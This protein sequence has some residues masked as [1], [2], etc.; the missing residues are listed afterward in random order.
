MVQLGECGRIANRI[1]RD[2]WESLPRKTRGGIAGGLVLLENLHTDFTLEIAA[3]K[4][5]GSD[6]LKNATAANVQ[7]ILAEFGESRLLVKEGGRTN[8]GLVKSLT[9]LLRNMRKAGLHNL[10][11]KERNAVL[12]EMQAF[13]AEKAKDELNAKKITFAYRKGMTSREV[14][15]GILAEAAKRKKAGEIAEYLI[16]AKLALRFPNQSIRNT[17]AS[18]ADEQ[19][20]EPGD[21]KIHD[22]VFHAT[23]SP[24]RGHYDKCRVNLD[25]GLRVFLLVPDAKLAGTRQSVE[26]DLENRVSVESIESFVSQNIEE[27]SEFSG[28]KIMG[29]FVDLLEKYNSRVAEVEANLSLQIEIPASLKKEKS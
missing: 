7:K 21:F 1:I 17:S 16:G 24:N 9:P 15:G 11:L 27:L 19:T 4:A 10:S 28:K 3:H 12:R 18:A 22:S 2:W 23:V 25:N 29:H 20:A 13:L 26:A 8:R 14:I 6:Q 5:E